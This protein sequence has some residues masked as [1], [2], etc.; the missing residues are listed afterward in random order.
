MSYAQVQGISVATDDIQRDGVTEKIQLIKTTDKNA[1]EIFPTQV[2]IWLAGANP[3]AIKST[4]G[5][6]FGYRITAQGAGT[7]TISDGS[8]GAVLD[9]IPANAPIGPGDGIPFGGIPFYTSLYINSEAAPS[10]SPAIT[11]LYA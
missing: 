8:S 9:T 5:R 10:A 4:P 11:V 3:G 6:Y 2:G 1:V 7:L